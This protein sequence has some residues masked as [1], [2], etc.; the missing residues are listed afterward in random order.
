MKMLNFVATVMLLLIGTYANA[1]DLIVKRD[2]SVI[3]AK[4]T[5][6]GTSEVEYKKWSNQDGPQYSIAVAD[7]LAINYQ[8][9]DKETFENVSSDEK[10]NSGK[11]EQTTQPGI[12]YVKPSDLSSEAKAAN[13][14]LIA[15]Y[16]APVSFVATNKAQKDIGKKKANR[17]V[18]CLRVSPNSLLT[19]DMIEV[20]CEVGSLFKNSKNGSVEWVVEKEWGWGLTS[21]PAILFSIRNKTN[22]TLYLDLANTFFVSSGQSTCYYIPSSTTDSRSSSSGASVNLG[23]VTNALGVGGFVG[24]IANGINVGG[25]AT[26]TTVSTVYSQRI[27][28]VAPQSTMKLPA[29]YMIGEKGRNI[30]QG[31]NYA[32]ISNSAL[33]S[34]QGY[35]IYANIVT[36]SGEM[37][38]GDK[39][40]RNYDE[41]PLKMSFYIAYSVD[42]QCT[43]ENVLES[44]YYLGEVFGSRNNNM[45]GLTNGS[46]SDAGVLHFMVK[47]SGDAVLLF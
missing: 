29:Q 22:Q 35:C 18:A 44:H 43:Q 39:Y 13:D 1:Q 4:V 21:N 6:V 9:G 15:K 20:K 5:K 40:E 12:V 7:I 46:I 25:G 47:I 24:G 31:F 17:G 45:T 27:V 36:P 37:M 8:N 30:A 14:A 33:M 3:Q 41:S 16:N 19:N 34:S 38:F 28:A 10:G 11:S 23:A 42:E 32:Q 26:N 2:G